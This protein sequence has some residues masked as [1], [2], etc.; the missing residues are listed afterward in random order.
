MI[1]VS[2]GKT[3]MS[4]GNTLLIND[5]REDLG[6]QREDLGLVTERNSGH[7]SDEKANRLGKAQP[8][9]HRV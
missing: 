5:Q 6:D 3:L 7:A 4:E 9:A 1:L 8:A 2:E